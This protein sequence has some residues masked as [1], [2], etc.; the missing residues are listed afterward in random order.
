MRIVVL[1]GAE[2]ALLRGRS[3]RV[4]DREEVGVLCSFGVFGAS[5]ITQKSPSNG[6]GLVMNA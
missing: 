6:S 1:E 5:R 3:L 4:V 2:I